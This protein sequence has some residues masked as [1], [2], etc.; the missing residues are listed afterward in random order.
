M[1][2]VVVDVE[3]RVVLPV[4]QVAT[5]ARPNDTL[6]K[7]AEWREAPVEQRSESLDVDSAVESEDACDHHQVGR[8]LHPQP[9]GVDARHRDQPGHRAVILRAIDG[10]FRCLDRRP[11]LRA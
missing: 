3:A 8:V 9:S 10:D 7:P 4:G 6:M 2:D 11:D 5:Q 1:A